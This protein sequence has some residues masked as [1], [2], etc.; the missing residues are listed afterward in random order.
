M[1]KTRVRLLS[2]FLLLLF[3]CNAD[4]II[5][6]HDCTDLS[7]IPTEWIVQ[8]KD[9]FNLSY[10]HTSHGSQ[11]VTGMSLLRG[12]P[13]SL[14]WYDNA[15]TDGGLS[16]H[17]YTPSGDLGNPDRYTWAARTRAM[18]DNSNNDRNVVLWSWCGQVGGTEAEI[19][20]YLDLMTEL[21]ADYP[22]VIFIYMTGHL[23]G[24]GVEGSVNQRNNQIRAHCIAHNSVLFDFADIESYDPDGNYFLDRGATDSCNYDGGNWADEW[25]AANPGECVSCTCAHSRCLN[26]QQKGKAF[27]WMMARLAGWD[28]ESNDPSYTEISSCQII[29]APGNYRLTH[30]ILDSNTERCIEITADDVC[31]DLQGHTI[32]G[33]E[34]G[35]Y[36][37]YV[38]R[39]TS[40]DSNITIKNGT[41]QNW[42]QS[43]IYIRSSN[44]NLLEDIRSLTSKY[45][46][47]QLRATKRNNIINVSSNGN[48][49]YGFYLYGTYNT[50]LTDVS[51]SGNGAG[52]MFSYAAYNW[53]NESEITDNLRTDIGVRTDDE[54]FC[55]NYLR[56][57]TGSGGRPIEYYYDKA[58][59][60]NRVLSELILCNADDSTIS[61]VSVYGT[62]NIMNNGVTVMLTDNA[63]FSNI[64]SIENTHGIMFLN[65]NNNIVTRCK[66]EH[67]M[68]DGLWFINSHANQVHNSAFNNNSHHGIHIV[69]GSSQN[70]I[71]NI[72]ANGNQGY[73][74]DMQEAS[75]NIISNSVFNDNYQGIQLVQNSSHN[76]F[77]DIDANSNVVCSVSLINHGF[78]SPNDNTFDN[79]TA[80]YNRWY[81]VVI[82]GASSNT[83]KNSHIEKNNGYNTYKGYGVFLQGPALGD[84]GANT[85][86]NNVFANDHNIYLTNA[87]NHKTA[88]N[89][90]ITTGPNIIDGPFI[91]GNYWNDYNHNDTDIDGFGEV[92]YMYNDYAIDYHPLVHTHVLC[93]D[94]VADGE[95]NILDLTSLLNAVVTG[96]MIDPCVG[97]TDGNRDLNILDVRR[98]IMY[99]NDPASSPLGCGC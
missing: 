19:Q 65:S 40:T 45:A 9:T 64:Q 35:K 8:A 96:D 85:I 48:P 53:L 37:I 62:D 32:D 63:V 4:A 26:C 98:L 25:C 22:E 17:D 23:N 33:D 10:G 47:V 5:I 75:D 1:T 95:I 11:I 18:L 81:G 24:G 70:E 92:P 72:V 44:D 79:I 51:A 34:T 29:S 16:L 76:T 61:N 39:T 80:S 31:L 12:E 66:A 82:D 42:G 54:W 28:G 38:S 55:P 84:H 49:Q 6:D 46:G 91:S 78:G 21:E 41:V 74:I 68:W 56:N 30:D 57:V 97:D 67:N 3:V 15:G 93:G 7:K 43:N 88:F 58:T 50:H 52:I 27:W 86:Y 36:G 59:I 89:T 87:V 83:L 20:Q 77:T 60:E 99:I 69:D 71:S 13:N 94:V 90:T 14:Y 73:G 2:V